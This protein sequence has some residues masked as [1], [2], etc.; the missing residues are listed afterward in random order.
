MLNYFT[1][2]QTQIQALCK[3]YQVERLYAFGSV[4][5]KDFSPK[6]DIDLI[7]AFDETQR[8]SLFRHFFGLKTALEKLF[9]RNVDLME[10][11]PIRNPILRE[12]I[13][14][15]KHIIYGQTS[16]KMAV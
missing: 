9:E 15:T 7:V 11:K 1:K 10:E 12:E 13:E 8:I 4:L 6:S 16:Q 2:Y 3:E 5:R 14:S